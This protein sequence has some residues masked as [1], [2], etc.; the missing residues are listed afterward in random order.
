MSDHPHHT[1]ICW[2]GLMV[3]LSATHAV[4]YGFVS[5]LG[6]IKDQHKTDASYLPVLHA[7]VRVGV[8][9]C[10]STV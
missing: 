2:D 6:H 5:W 4:G 9:Q 10:N 1:T 8:W 3:S 7:G